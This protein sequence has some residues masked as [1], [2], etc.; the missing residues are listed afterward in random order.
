MPYTAG[1]GNTKL[2]NEVLKT[3]KKEINDVEKKMIIASSHCPRSAV[4]IVKIIRTGILVVECFEKLWKSIP[5]RVATV[6]EQKVVIHNI[7]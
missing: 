7:N 5:N 6:L 4:L 2:K 3:P 1:N